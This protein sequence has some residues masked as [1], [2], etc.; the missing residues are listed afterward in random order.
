MGEQR[1]KTWNKNLRC[2]HLH[3]FSYDLEGN[4][5]D[6]HCGSH[7]CPE[8]LTCYKIR[9]RGEKK[10]NVERRYSNAANATG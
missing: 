9:K 10:K 6:I 2:T 8:G 7:S 1:M 3:F 5:R 4:A